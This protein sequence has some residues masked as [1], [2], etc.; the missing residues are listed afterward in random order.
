[1][2]APSVRLHT[3]FCPSCGS[4]ASTLALEAG[5]QLIRH[6]S[7]FTK[8]TGERVNCRRSWVAVPDAA[9]ARVDLIPVEGRH[10]SD[11]TLR[12][13]T[14]HWLESIACAVGGDED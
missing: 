12:A 1:M 4:H 6:Q 8:S 3:V 7:R 10:Q 2:A 14:S 9:R 5:P 11:D 13:A